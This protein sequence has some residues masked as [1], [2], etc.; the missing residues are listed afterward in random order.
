MWSLLRDPNY[1]RSKFPQITLLG[2]VG[3]VQGTAA[4]GA[5]VMF[6]PGG[7]SQVAGVGGA[8][9]FTSVP[10]GTYTIISYDAAMTQKASEDIEVTT[11]G[12]TNVVFSYSP[13]T[14]C[15]C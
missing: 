7:P 6:C 3:T 15:R 8:F 5:I 12:T 9:K 4:E 1:W 10:I 13:A 14:D 11:G 2:S